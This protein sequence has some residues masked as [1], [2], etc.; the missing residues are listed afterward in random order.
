M[1]IEQAF[2][3]VNSQQKPIFQFKAGEM[4]RLEIYQMNIDVLK[5]EIENGHE[6]RREL[7]N[8]WYQG[9]KL[10][11][12]QLIGRKY[13]LDRKEEDLRKEQE[14]VNPLPF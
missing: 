2:N 8:K 5:W 11:K 1:N 4:T 7:G 12:E 10:D 13:Q 14:R 6:L 3:F 9:E